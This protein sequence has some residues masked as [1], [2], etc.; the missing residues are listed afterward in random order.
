MPW[1]ETRM[2]SQKNMDESLAK[3]IIQDKEE[4]HI[5]LDLI[6]EYEFCEIKLLFSLEKTPLYLSPVSRIWPLAYSQCSINICRM[7]KLGDGG[8]LE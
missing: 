6:L 1:D 4:T 3:R 2:S 8:G 7:D 5:D